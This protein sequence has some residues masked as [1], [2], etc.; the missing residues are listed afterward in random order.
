M[1][2]LLIILL[3]LFMPVSLWAAPND[4][5]VTDSGMESWTDAN[6]L[7][8]WSEYKEGACTI[9]QESSVVHSGD[10]SCR[11][12]IDATGKISIYQNVSLIA[13][14]TYY[15]IIWNKASATPSSSYWTLQNNTSNNYLQADLVSW[16]ASVNNK[17]FN[18]S[19]VWDD[20]E[21]TFTA[22]T[23]AEYRFEIIRNTHSKSLY[24]DDVSIKEMWQGQVNSVVSPLYIDGIKHPA[25]VDGIN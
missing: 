16:G 6:D 12:D 10:Y 7:T 8:N 2:R 14:R 5:E 9:N 22:E 11:F 21:W 20:D 25:A 19:T 24:F 3:I 4:E 15:L 13:G 23:T 17:T 18:Q 1:K